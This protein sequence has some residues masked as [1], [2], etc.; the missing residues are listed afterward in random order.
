MTKDPRGK[1]WDRVTPARTI[2]PV[3]LCS[4]WKEG[5]GGLATL[6]SAGGCPQSSPRSSPG[7]I[8]PA[9]CPPSPQSCPAGQAPPAPRCPWAVAAPGGCPPARSAEAAGC[10]AGCSGQAAPQSPSTA[11]ARAARGPWRAW[12]QALGAGAAAADPAACPQRG[13]AGGFSA[14]RAVRIGAPQALRGRPGVGIGREGRRQARSGSGLHLASGVPPRQRSGRGRL[15]RPG[16]AGRGEH[17]RAPPARGPA[18]G[19]RERRAPGSGAAPAAQAAV[20]QLP[21]PR[22]AGAAER[23]AVAAVKAKGV[24]RSVGSLG[25]VVFPGPASQLPGLARGLGCPLLSRSPPCRTLAG[26]A[27]PAWAGPEHPSGWSGGRPLLRQPVLHSLSAHC[28]PGILPG[29]A[30]TERN[31]LCMHRAQRRA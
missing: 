16:G 5:R 1:V 9:G 11:G 14:G 20:I 13:A 18:G 30:A 10:Q 17:G 24:R 4:C 29:T 15:G 25:S 22:Q 27:A 2:Q 12:P 7:R 31:Q 19:Q 26:R 8:C 6:P 23:L 3:S 28:V 21:A